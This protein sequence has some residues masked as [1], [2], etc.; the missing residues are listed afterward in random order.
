VVATVSE[1]R[2]DE[3][4]RRSGL[5][6][7]TIR[8]YQREGLIPPAA[9]A[10]RAKVYGQEHLDRLAQIKDLQARR[11]SLAAI[12]ALLENERPGVVDIFSGEGSLSYSLD[13]LVERS[14]GSPQ[15]A[16]RLRDAGLLR[17]PKDFGRDAYDATDLDVLRAVVELQRHALPED[18]IVELAAIYVDGVERMQLEVLDLFAG[19]RGAVWGD[20]EI[21]A[22]Q[23]KA[24]SA[25]GQLL[26]LVTR[27]VEYVHQRTL[28]RLTLGAIESG[29]LGVPPEPPGPSDDTDSP[30]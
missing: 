2:I 14:G 28:Q 5:T 1:I 24:A 6:V 22:F 11:F 3:L 17:D 18:V 21:T 9:R 19:R 7:D 10:G 29:R 23:N 16:H 12:K 15:L 13:D 25:A 27:I 20:E 8:F 26:P 30:A 4:A